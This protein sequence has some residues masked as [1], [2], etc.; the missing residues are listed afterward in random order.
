MAL[1]LGYRSAAANGLFAALPEA[2]TISSTLAMTIRRAVAD[3]ADILAASGAGTFA[4]TF[5]HLYPPEDLD[6]IPG[7][8]LQPGALRRL[9]ARSAVRPLD[10]R[11][12]RPGDRLCTGGAVPSAAPGGDAGLR[13]ASAALS[14]PRR[15]GRRSRPAAARDRAR[16]GWRGRTRRLWIGV[17]SENLGAQRLYARYG[18]S[19]VGE[20]EFSVSARRAIASSSWPGP[21]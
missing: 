5:G 17:W 13:R 19:K 14:A 1:T 18:F 21:A 12:G 2:A 20:Y 10:R 7:R 15:A 8:G 9:G 11:G 4:E 3:D 6:A 16:A